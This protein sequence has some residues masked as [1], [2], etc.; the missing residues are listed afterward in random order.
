MLDDPNANLNR[1]MLANITVV[2]K[3]ATGW[4]LG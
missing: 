4:I 2:V 3:G 1:E